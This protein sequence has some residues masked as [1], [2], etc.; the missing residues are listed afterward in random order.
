M[1]NAQFIYG[2]PA[3]VTIYDATNG[4]LHLGYL[5]DVSV[6]GEPAATKTNFAQMVGFL[7]LHKFSATMLE[8]N[9]SKI[10]E[11]NLR[12]TVEQTVYIVGGGKMLTLSGM[13]ISY[14]E[15]QKSNES[16]AH[17]IVLTAQTAIEPTQAENLIG[18][19]GKFETD[20]DADGAANGWSKTGTITSIS[21]VSSHISGNAQQLELSTAFG[22]IYK[23]ITCPFTSPQKVTF[24]AYIKATAASQ[25]RMII[26]LRDSVDALIGSAYEY[27]VSM[28]LNEETRQSFTTI[29]NPAGSL[30]QSVRVYFFNSYSGT[31]NIQIDNAQL[32]L[33]PLRDFRDA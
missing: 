23:A 10:T 32:E 16:D 11:L 20:T 15:D 22:G 4:W 25:F 13:L 14:S 28:I 33:G 31:S 1:A 8:T 21:L 5:A 9:Q 29:V 24:S 12:R 3:D 26:E 17:T 6:M 7:I 30:C 19:D 27:E 2:G 18:S